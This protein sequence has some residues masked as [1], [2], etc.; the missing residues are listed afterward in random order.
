MIVLTFKNTQNKHSEYHT[1]FLHVDTGM[2]T[3]NLLRRTICRLA[4]EVDKH[5]DRISVN[6][7][8]DLSAQIK[9]SALGNLMSSFA[10]VPFCANVLKSYF[11]CFIYT[12]KYIQL[13][14]IPKTRCNI[15]V[16]ICCCM[17]QLKKVVGCLSIIF[18]L[19]PAMQ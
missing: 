2:D 8:L 15:H 10:F 1:T 12:H 16:I 9:R 13:Q 7:M 19:V 6:A 4:K 3:A 17:Y 18:T 5:H 11:F 14:T